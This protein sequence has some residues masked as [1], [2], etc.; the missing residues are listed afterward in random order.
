MLTQEV[1]INA[2]KLVEIAR[3]CHFK[4]EPVEKTIQIIN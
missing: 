3:L 4:L 2:S 1:V